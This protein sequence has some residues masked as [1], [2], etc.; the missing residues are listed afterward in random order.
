MPFKLK[1]L[2]KVNDQAVTT[3]IL[4][5]GLPVIASNL[6]RT[7]MSLADVAMVGRLG[8]GALAATGMG[9]MLI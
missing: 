7:I 4:T 8:A 5:L 1:Q 6:S 2:F 3:Q 9:S